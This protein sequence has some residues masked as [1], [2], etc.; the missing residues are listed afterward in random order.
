M[1]VWL[2]VCVRARVFALCM[3]DV[4]NGAIR[5]RILKSDGVEFLRS[6]P[7]QS[8]DLVVAT[9]AVHFMDRASL[10]KAGPMSWKDSV[11]NSSHCM[12]KRRRFAL[13]SLAEF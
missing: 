6:Q 13:R 4:L 5:P 12:R 7:D 11:S 1:C 9:F 3:C 10:D 2:C 8:L